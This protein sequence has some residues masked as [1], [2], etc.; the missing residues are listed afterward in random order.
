[1][2]EITVRELQKPCP[3]QFPGCRS[4]SALYILLF[5]RSVIL[6]DGEIDTIAQQFILEQK[7]GTVCCINHIASEL[8]LKKK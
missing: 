2:T 5:N 7:A 4:T 6:P 8:L 3:C 1:M